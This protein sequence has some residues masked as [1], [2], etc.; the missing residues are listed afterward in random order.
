MALLGL[1]HARQE[2]LD[3]DEVGCDVDFEDPV[4]SFGCTIYNTLTVC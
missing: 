2:F 3:Q 4:D 1:Q